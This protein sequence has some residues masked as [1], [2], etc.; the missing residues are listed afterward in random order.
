MHLVTKRVLGSNNEPVS[1]LQEMLCIEGHLWAQ[2]SGGINPCDLNELFVNI[3][4]DDPI[5]FLP[6]GKMVVGSIQRVPEQKEA[7]YLNPC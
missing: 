7:I 5:Q 2:L 4:F 1:Y 3:L 6:S